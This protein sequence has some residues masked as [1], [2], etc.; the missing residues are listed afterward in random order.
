MATSSNLRFQANQALVAAR[1]RL[2]QARSL[3]RIAPTAA[4]FPQISTD[5]NAWTARIGQPAAQWSVRGSH[6]A[7]PLYAERLCDSI[8]AQLRRSIFWP[9]AENV[10]AANASLQ[11][12]AADLGNA[13]LVLSAEL[14]AD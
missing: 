11:S 9:R 6:S 7:S 4:Y 10:E 2:N 5:P 13:Q 3:A 14:A 1:D 12:T 8:F